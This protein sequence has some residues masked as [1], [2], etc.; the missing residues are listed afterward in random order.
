MKWSAIAVLATG[1][2]SVGPK[3]PPTVRAQIMAGVVGTV[4]AGGAIAGAASAHDEPIAT[5]TGVAIA[6]AAIPMAVIFLGDE[7]EEPTTEGAIYSQLTS[8]LLSALGAS[9]TFS[10][11]MLGA[12]I[13]GDETAHPTRAW[14]GVALGVGAGSIASVYLGKSLPKWARVVVGAAVVGSAATLGYQLG[15]G[16]PP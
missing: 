5:Q 14:Y 13:A 7:A 15:G 11:P 4:V 6:T 12:Y 1:C 16:G 9:L 8:G 2:M 3:H 10:A